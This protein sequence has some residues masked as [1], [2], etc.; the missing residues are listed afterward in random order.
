MAHRYSSK[1]KILDIK[2]E[3]QTGAS[4]NSPSTPL[5]IEPISLW[6]PVY[7]RLFKTLSRHTLN[8][9]SGVF[10]GGEQMRGYS[11]INPIKRGKVRLVDILGF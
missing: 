11:S 6:F 10:K 1:V 3:K 2:I 5:H 4:Q 8:M 7:H 9:D